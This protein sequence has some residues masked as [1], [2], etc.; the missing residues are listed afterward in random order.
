MARTK[1]PARTKKSELAKSKKKIMG[2]KMKRR[3]KQVQ[4]KIV[5]SKVRR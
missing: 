2:R 1:K 4:S 3:E 5:L